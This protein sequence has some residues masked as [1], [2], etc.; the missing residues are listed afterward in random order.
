[1]CFCQVCRRSRAQGAV[2]VHQGWAALQ[3]DL[4]RLEEQPSRSCWKF[5]EDKSPASGQ[6]ELLAHTQAGDCLAKQ[7]L[8]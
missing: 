5:N 2:D 4:G 7:Q 6:G 3:R 8:W 1:M